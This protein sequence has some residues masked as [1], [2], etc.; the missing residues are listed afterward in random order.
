MHIIE[1]NLKSETRKNAVNLQRGE[2]QCCPLLAGL[3]HDLKQ[4]PVFFS[5]PTPALLV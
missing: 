3:Y 2:N 4:A 5:V 1:Q